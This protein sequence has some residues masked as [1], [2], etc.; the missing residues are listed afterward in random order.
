MKT[1]IKTIIGL[2]II[3]MTTLLLTTA[4]AGPEEAK[5]GVPFLGYL[6]GDEDHTLIFGDPPQAHQ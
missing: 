4:I 5:N 1:I 3:L 6:Q 2:Q